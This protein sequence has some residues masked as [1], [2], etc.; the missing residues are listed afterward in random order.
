MKSAAP[1]AV[2]KRDSQETMYS[3]IF[4]SLT[5]N[6]SLSLTLCQTKFL[7]MQ[8][9]QHTAA[10]SHQSGI[11]HQKRVYDKQWPN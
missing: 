6:Y 3:M 11:V 4:I 7:L 9:E 1:R 10:A 5:V 8:T 2:I